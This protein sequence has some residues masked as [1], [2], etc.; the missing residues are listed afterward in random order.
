MPRQMQ[1]KTTTQS[2]E[3]T[4]VENV[5]TTTEKE[6]KVQKKE[7]KKY[8]DGDYI[9]C[10]SII[11]GGLN[12]NCRSGNHYEFDNYNT[13]CEIEYR[14]LVS[15][16]RKRSEHIFLPRIIID[17]EDFLEEFPQVQQFYNTMYTTEDLKEI[18]N[19]PNSQM[20]DVIRSLP[21]ELISTLKSL[22]ATMISS[23]EID[24]IV[25]VKTLTEVLNADFNFLS[26]IFK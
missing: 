16:I 13:T 3:K 20:A 10:H 9:I 12:I 14:D 11:A 8:S 24:S 18:L 7:V 4:G 6:V 15:L 2:V 23:G 5:E 21:N 1:K 22:A 17:D 25:K 26:E 19:L